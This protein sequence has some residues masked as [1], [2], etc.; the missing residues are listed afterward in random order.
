MADPLTITLPREAPVV[1]AGPSGSGKSTF[2]R[3]HF[4]PTQI[5]S[6]DTMRALISDDEA[7]QH[8][9]GLAFQLLYDLVDKRLSLRRLTVVDST[10]LSAATRRDLHRIAER[11]HMPV[12][13]LVFVADAALCLARDRQRTRQ[14]GSVVIARQM[15]ALEDTLRRAPQEGFAAIYP[16]DAKDTSQVQIQYERA[17]VDLSG[18]A[19]PFDIIGDVHGCYEELVALL[20]QLGY[21]PQQGDDGVWRHPAGRQA[22]FLGDLTDRGPASV[23]VLRL[24]I[25]M[26]QAGTAVYTPGNHCNKLMRY[27]LGRKVRVAHGLAQTLAEFDALPPDERAALVAATQRLIQTAPPYLILD[28]GRLVVAHAGIKD[29][30]IGEVS[31]RIQDFC[32][33]GDPTGENDEYGHPIRRDWAL[34]YR[35]SA[36]V[37][38]GHTVVP[39]P[40]WINNTLNIDQGCVFGGQLTALRW[41]ERTIVQVPAR[42][43]YTDHDAPDVDAALSLGS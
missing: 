16:L 2:A 41:P 35:G 27:L 9:S 8:V 24:V 18:L 22:V 13:L 40:V 15:A 20:E 3:Q 42:R 32:L 1:L 30:M 5:V 33:Y 37:I 6:S 31:R 39:E 26:V 25:P 7:D 19:G 29:W 17:G 36:A 14:V 34:Q 10:A 12:V 38:Y 11:H 23:P 43:V 21:G 28:G 4:G